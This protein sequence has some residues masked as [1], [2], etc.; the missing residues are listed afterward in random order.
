M[1]ES[2]VTDLACPR[3]G[4]T[5]PEDFCDGEDVCRECHL[6]SGCR[7]CFIDPEVEAEL[8]EDLYV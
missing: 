7:E 2:V 3:C 6:A 8:R 1:G 5:N 4:V